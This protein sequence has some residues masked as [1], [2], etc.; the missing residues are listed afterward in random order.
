MTLEGIGGDQTKKY[1]IC[2][3]FGLH[4]LKLHFL[5]VKTPFEWPWRM[6][7]KKLN[8]RYLRRGFWIF[9]KNMFLN[10]YYVVPM[11]KIRYVTAF[12]S[13]FSLNV[14]IEEVWHYY[15]ASQGWM[16]NS[17]S[18]FFSLVSLDLYSRL[19]CLCWIWKIKYA[20]RVYRFSIIHFLKRIWHTFYYK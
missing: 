11:K 3:N 9:L 20:G 14:S 10:Y 16:V 8:L 4:L 15:T 1:K 19:P 18:G 12:L 2:L 6:Q 7:S 5:L 17:K 13:K